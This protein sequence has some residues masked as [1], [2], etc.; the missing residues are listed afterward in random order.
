MRDRLIRLLHAATGDDG[1][2]AFWPRLTPSGRRVLRLAFLEARQLGHPCLADE[3]LLLG[4]LRDGTSPAA[5]TLRARGLDLTTARADLLRVGPTLGPR[6][7]PAAALRS[8][9]IHVDQVRHRLDASFGTHAVQSA[10][11]R[12]RRRPRWRGGHARPDP[13]C[14][15]ILAKRAF[16]L[17]AR[18]A[19]QRGDPGIGPQHLLYGV[20]QDARDPLGTQLSRRSRAELTMLGFTQGR[21]QPVRLILEARGIT[22]ATMLTEIA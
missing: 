8:L 1:T 18:H 9:G 2:G 22:I 6:A 10:E 4:L 15:Y 13:L 16:Q 14:G 12:V 19:A 7:D 21:H 5:A 3:H 11:R 20:L 17:A